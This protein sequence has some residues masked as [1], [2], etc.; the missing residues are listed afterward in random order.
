MTNLESY[1]QFY[2]DKYLGG[3]H[4]TLKVGVTFYF[5]KDY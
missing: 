2:M 4:K 5:Y 1:Y 3:S